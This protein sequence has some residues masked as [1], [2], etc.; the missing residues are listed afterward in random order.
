MT[1]FADRRHAGR[2]LAGRV[3][4]AKLDDPLVLALPRG[5]VPVGYEV[6]QLLGAELDVLI[7]RKIGVPWRPELGA[8]AVTGDGPPVFDSGVLELAGL[9]PE[10]LEPVVTTLAGE[11][12]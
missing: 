8:G 4:L 10:D 2:E 1:L 7:V 11:S 5:G 9:R 12:S 3:A 6:A